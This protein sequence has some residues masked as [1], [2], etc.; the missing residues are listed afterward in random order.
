[1]VNANV[2][3]N[4]LVLPTVDHDCQSLIVKPLITTFLLLMGPYEAP[5]LDYTHFE[6]TQHVVLVW[7]LSYDW[8]NG[9]DLLL[10][11]TPQTSLEGSRSITLPNWM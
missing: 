11:V 10:K 9:R 8:S 7:P 2:N 6:D 3:A 5:K 1:M 4:H